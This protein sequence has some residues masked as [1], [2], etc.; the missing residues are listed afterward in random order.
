MASLN[1]HTTGKVDVDVVNSNRTAWTEQETVQVQDD[2]VVIKSVSPGEVLVLTD[3]I[4]MHNVLSTT[5]TFVAFVATS[6]NQCQTRTHV[7][8]AYVSPL[9]TESINLSTGIEVPG[10]HQLCAR[11]TAGPPTHGITFSFSGYFELP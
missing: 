8:P 1:V 10:G 5:D 3:V 4:M 11:V 6:S 7:L 2:F 9:K